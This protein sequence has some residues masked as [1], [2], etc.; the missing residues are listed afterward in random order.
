MFITQLWMKKSVLKL[1]RVDIM[2]RWIV[3]LESVSVL[4]KTVS[5]CNNLQFY[6]WLRVATVINLI[7]GCPLPL[8]VCHFKFKITIFKQ[9]QHLLDPDFIRSAIFCTSFF[10]YLSDCLIKV[11]IEMCRK[12]STEIDE[13]LIII[14]YKRVNNTR[15]GAVTHLSC[16]TFSW[17]R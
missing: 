17:Q 13:T 9:V 8:F 7:E 2:N 11:V 14:F 5:F 4:I 10:F 3:M 15:A 6:L 16:S 12:K 1:T